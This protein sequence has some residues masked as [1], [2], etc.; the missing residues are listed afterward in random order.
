MIS[1][2]LTVLKGEMAK[3]EAQVNEADESVRKLIR[4]AE[5]SGANLE[6]LEG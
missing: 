1:S 6:W 3:Y 5:E 2:R 4:E